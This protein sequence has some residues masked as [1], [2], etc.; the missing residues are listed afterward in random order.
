MNKENK[1]NTGAEFTQIKLI[2]AKKKNN[3][4]PEYRMF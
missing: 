2:C 4:Y 1:T 3:K